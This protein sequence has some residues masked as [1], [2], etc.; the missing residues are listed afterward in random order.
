MPDGGTM[1]TIK[2][3]LNTSMLIAPC[4]INC[5]L[6]RA[7]GRDRNPCPGC[8]G[9]DTSKA[10]TCAHCRIKNCAK[11]AAGGFKYCFEC[12]EFPCERVTHLDKRYRTRYATSPIQNLI[13]IQASGIR[14]FVKAEDQKWTCPRCSAMLCMHDPQCHSC[15]YV[16][17]N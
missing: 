3:T 1:P 6:C 16:W 11:L 17:H 4:G 9:E 15:G 2:T 8:R 13:D 5:R 10:K 14:R 12:D 7:Y